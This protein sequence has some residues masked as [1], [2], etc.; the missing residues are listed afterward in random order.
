MSRPDYVRLRQIRDSIRQSRQIS[1]S[2]LD[3]SLSLL[4]SS[5]EP[6]ARSR[7]MTM[8]VLLKNTPQAQK[9]KVK[10][11]VTPLLSS[12]DELDRKSAELVLK[13]LS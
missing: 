2:D 10:G 7:V 4:K 5:S 9:D 13:S 6:T 8:F 3:W 1:D 11:A 12:Q